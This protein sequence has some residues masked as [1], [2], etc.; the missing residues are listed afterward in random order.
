MSLA[1]SDRPADAPCC[2]FHL[3]QRAVD[4]I[5]AAT[6]PHPL[7]VVLIFDDEGVVVATRDH[8]DVG[9][10]ELEDSCALVVDLAPVVG[11][12]TVVLLS[13]DPGFGTDASCAAVRQAFLDTSRRLQRS[14]TELVEWWLVGDGIRHSVASAC[15]GF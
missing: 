1:C 8:A 5:V 3:R 9:P 2:R 12:A 4:A 11:G 6:W 15:A 14:G 7:L 13:L 10:T